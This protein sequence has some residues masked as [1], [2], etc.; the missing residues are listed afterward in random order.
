MSKIKCKICGRKLT[1]SKSKMIGIGPVCLKKTINKIK[2]ITL[3]D[4]VK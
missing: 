1:S 3:L 4:F 2:K